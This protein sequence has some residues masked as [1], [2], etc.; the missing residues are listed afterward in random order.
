VRHALIE[1]QRAFR[2]PPGLVADG[3]DMGTVIFPDAILKIFL[4]ASV[5]QRATRRYKQLK[6]KGESVNL[7]R[8]FKDI[9]K[10]DERDSTRAIAPL[11]PAIDAHLVDSTD[12]SIEQVMEV[13]H[14][15]LKTI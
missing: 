2:Q 8:L 11:K 13:I 10:R 5:E 4:T 12:L 15:L 14:N 7:S 1:R 6:E 9:E 3:R